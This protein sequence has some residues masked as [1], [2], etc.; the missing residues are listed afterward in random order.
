VTNQNECLHI[1]TKYENY[2]VLYFKWNNA[3]WQ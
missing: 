1:S 2:D 3:A